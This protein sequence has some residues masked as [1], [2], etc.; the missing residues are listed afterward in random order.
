MTNFLRSLNILLANLI[1]LGV[2]TL[3]AA[4]G[5]L[6]YQTFTGDKRTLQE[7]QERLQ[8]SQAEINRLTSQLAQREQQIQTLQTELAEKQKQIEQLRT[9]VRLLKV[10]HRLAHL[11]VLSQEISPQ[12]GQLQ[13]RLRF[14]EVDDAGKPIDKP[15]EFT[16]EGDVVHVGALVIKFADEY[17]EGGENF[18]GAAICLFHRLYGDKQPPEKGF[19]LDPV[20]SRPAIYQTGQQMSDWER[21]LWKNFWEYSNDPDKARQLGIRAAHGDAVYQQLRPGKRY[22]VLLR[23][24]GEFT[25]QPLEE[26]LGTT[27]ATT[28]T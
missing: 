24:T 15:K 23:S 10:Q 6:A 12:T 11:E 22:K 26:E 3:L 9:A 8:A 25:I 13:T 20:G 18:R 28:S 27:K 21:Q 7:V 5:Y 16:I 2:L 17:V 19:P 4:G 14:I 1:G